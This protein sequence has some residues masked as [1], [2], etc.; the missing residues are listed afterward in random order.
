[1]VPRSIFVQAVGSGIA[2][3]IGYSIGVFARWLVNYLDIPFKD[4]LSSP[5]ARVALAS[6]VTFLL[7]FALWQ[8]VS[9]QNELRLLFGVELITPLF[10]IPVIFLS[11]VLFVILLVLGRFIKLLYHSLINLL[12]RYLSRRLSIVLG[13]AL[14]LVIIVLTI[15]GVV[16]RG[17]FNIAN[18]SFS[19]S[20]AIVDPALRRPEAKETSGSTES[21]VS[22]ESLG[23]NGRMFVT[24]G[25]TAA[26]IEKVTNQPAMQPIRSYV[27]LDSKD[28]LKERSDLLLKELIRAGAFER[29]SLLITTSVGDG[30]LDSQAVDPFEYVNN[31]DTAIAGIQYS[32]LPSALSLFADAEDVKTSSQEVF[33]DIYTYWLTLPE[34]DRPDIYMYGLSLGSYGVESVLNS[35]ELFNAPIKGALLAGPPF[36]NEFHRDVMNNRDPSSPIWRPVINNGTTVRFTGKDNALDNPTAEWGDTRIVYMQHASDPITWFSGDLFYKNP[37]WLNDDQRG[38]DISDNFIWI[39]IVTAYQ[40]GLDMILSFNYPA[41]YAH[42]Y[43]P[44]SH[45]DAWAAITRPSGWSQERAATIKAHY[46]S[47]K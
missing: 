1:M 7:V 22:W 4:R 14:A 33:R 19:F 39:P 45:V 35:V 5:H 2:I 17:I 8:F 20:N 13:S 25:P 30:W 18:E 3:A 10:L 36:I 12:D 37:E 41:G 24:S 26:D 42:N 16:V 32:Y 6:A 34:N 46:Q 27:G 47:E 29:K 9:W 44:S 15:N 23:R 21:L 38:P 40:I 28:S 31:G 43:A 11:C